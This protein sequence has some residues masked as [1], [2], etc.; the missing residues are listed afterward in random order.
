MGFRDFL[1]DIASFNAKHK[2]RKISL[3][4]HVKL[5]K[6]KLF[7]HGDPILSEKD[8]LELLR[9]FDPHTRQVYS[10]FEFIEYLKDEGLMILSSDGF[11]R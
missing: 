5:Y 1:D 9:L 7:M 4:P 8:V 3:L 10:T 2:K 6:S 11:T